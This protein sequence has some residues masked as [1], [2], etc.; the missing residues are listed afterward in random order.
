MRRLI[1]IIIYV[2]LAAAASAAEPTPKAQGQRQPG[3]Q[4]Y[5]VHAYDDLTADILD[6]KCLAQDASGFLWLATSTGLYRFDG[7][8]FQSFRTHDGDVTRGY[9]I[10]RMATD[11]QGRLWCEIHRRAFIY[12]TRRDRYTPADRRQWPRQRRHDG[13][14]QD[15]EPP[16][17]PLHRDRFGHLWRR[18]EILAPGLLQ[19]HVVL[20]DNQDNVWY[21]YDRQ[22]FRI[23]FHPTTYTTLPSET[24]P[25]RWAMRDSYGNLWLSDRY[26]GNLSIYSA[27]NSIKAYVT[28]EGDISS[29]PLPFAARP[30]VIFEDSR[31]DIWVGTKPHGLFRLRLRADGSGYDMRQWRREPGG[32]NDNEIIDIRED[33][34]G[35]LWTLGFHHGP[36]CVEDA[37][38]ERPRFTPVRQ[39]LPPGEVKYRSLTITR[40]GV[41]LAASSEGLFVYDLA[42]GPKALAEGR[43]IRRHTHEQR[44]GESLASASLKSV[45]E[46]ADG[47]LYV[48]TRD[49]GIDRLTSRSLL[50]PTLSFRH[51]DTSRGFPADYI[52]AMAEAPDGTLWLTAQNSIIEW[53]PA[54]PLPEGAAI[55]LT[56]EGNDF[57]E[58]TPAPRADGSWVFGTL[59]GAIA[60]RL[61]DLRR[62]AAPRAAAFP[63][64][65]TSV[66]DADTLTLPPH[67]RSLNISFAALCYAG[68]RPVTYAVRL[69]EAGDENGDEWQYLGT[70]HDMA[71][72]RLAPGRY[73]LL[74]RSTDGDGSWQAAA[75]R[76]TVIVTPA[77]HETWWAHA[78][79]LLLIALLLTGAS[80]LWRYVRRVE[81][82]RRELLDAYMQLLNHS[83]ATTGP[84]EAEHQEFR[85]RLLRGSGAAPSADDRMIRRV[86]EY[87]DQHI[88]DPDI[89]IDLMA[90][91][92]AVSR[93][94]LNHKLKQ[95]MGVTPSEMIREARIKRACQ[96]LADGQRSINDIAYAC[97]FAD[98][99]Y[100]SRCFK[101][102]TGHSPSGYRLRQ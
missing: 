6:M 85:E 26:T 44:R 97:G 28:A 23:S 19:A 80:A 93:S 50:T 63:I 81:G 78:L 41:M 92:A 84:R 72:Q 79:W 5:T 47:H 86:V 57:S 15:T 65:L 60:I 4:G 62:A 20:E 25:M 87:I 51:Y 59:D 102:A 38:G 35:R 61:G 17:A 10:G 91:D 82:K 7:Y 46:T 1:H 52:K 49:R 58:S 16:E 66:G 88:A 55:R 45:V 75:R 31:H 70:T 43:G 94:Q 32:L 71:F 100:F 74:L 101:A 9:A 30:Y 40:A 77:W 73:T 89:D 54:R 3:C 13:T 24:Q 39:T 53:H 90:R 42:R 76:I 68:A 99:K 18:G 33:A 64:R 95:I 14:F 37:Q 29:K 2:L 56:L 8:R 12:D 27:D 69:A 67:E 98:P 11:R 48:C 96:L 22:L 21:L 36:C 34:D 83:R